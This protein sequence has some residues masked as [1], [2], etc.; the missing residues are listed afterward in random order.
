[1]VRP[2]RL[3]GYYLSILL[4]TP[5]TAVRETENACGDD[6][7]EVS[8]LAKAVSAVCT[9]TKDGHVEGSEEA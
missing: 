3:V 5:L 1:M 7:S 4:C 8:A 2:S 6:E 9:T